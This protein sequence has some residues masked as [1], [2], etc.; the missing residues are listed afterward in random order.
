MAILLY[1]NG[2]TENYFP[3]NKTFTEKEIIDIFPDFPKLKSIRLNSISNVWVVYGIELNDPEEFNKISSLILGDDVYSPALFI[4]DSEINEKWNMTDAIKINYEK[5]NIC[6]KE[7]IEKTA[8]NIVNQ[9]TDENSHS[10]RA[11]YLPQLINMGI[12]ED[13]KLMF[14]FNPNEQSKEFYSASEFEQFSIK[15]YDYL[16]VNKI[17]KEPFTIYSDK[18]A[19]II[20][21]KTS[22]IDFLNI[23]LK[24]FEKKE[25]Y[26]KCTNISKMIAKWDKITQKSSVR[27]RNPIKNIKPKSDIKDNEII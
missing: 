21:E 25:D 14:A 17:N 2:I 15:V 1:S 11:N 23:L 16:H 6:V 8:I 22:I 10:D 9:M 7:L 12:T 3:S 5:F 20:I 19:I 24:H 13:K 18:K 26:E 27:K 4:N